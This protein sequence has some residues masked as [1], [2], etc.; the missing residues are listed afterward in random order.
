MTIAVASG[1]GGT[2]KTSVSLSLALSASGPVTLLDC[3]VEEPNAGLFLNRKGSAETP[4]TVPVP[5]IDNAL[6]TACGECGRFCEYNAIVCIGTSVLVFS[7]L[8]H[9]CGGCTLVC[10][11]KAISEG[12]VVIGT[13]S[14]ASVLREDAG[15]PP[16]RFV[17]GLLAIGNTLSPTLIRAVKSC[18][19]ADRFSDTRALVIID[20]PPGTSCPVV[21]AVTGA[22]YV[23]LVTE[24]TPF[25][26]HDL[27]LAVKTMRA[28][29][30]P[31]GVIINRS[32]SGN[33]RV[34]SW[35]ADEKI[36]VLMQIPEDRRIAEGYSRGVPLITAAPEYRAQFRSVLAKLSDGGVA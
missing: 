8:C 16:L 13:L 19:A 32:D 9:S 1:K 34:R 33:D 2:G 4:V 23:V 3:D 25:G 17:Q 26:L 5:V 14:E 21:T 7:E 22:D 30:L 18:A 6:C 12:P 15:E 29:N 31:F 35:C 20:S 11:R 24:P 28:A 36:P 27:T 10:P